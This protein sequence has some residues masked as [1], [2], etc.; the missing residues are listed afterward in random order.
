MEIS[1]IEEVMWS[2]LTLKI[3]IV[4][5]PIAQAES[6][7]SLEEDFEEGF[8]EGLNAD[9]Y[10]EMDDEDCEGLEDDEQDHREEDG[11]V[12]AEAAPGELLV[13]ICSVRCH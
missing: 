10:E 4:F 7:D 13:S 3:C 11:E 2:Q 9:S 12:S 5:L 6:L 1:I 8:L